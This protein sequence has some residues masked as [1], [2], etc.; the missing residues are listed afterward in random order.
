MS[1]KERTCNDCGFEWIDIGGEGQCPACGS[2]S[3]IVDGDAF[4]LAWMDE[5]RQARQGTDH[6]TKQAA[7]E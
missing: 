4:G 2:L 6:K 5:F 7:H 1:A 3:T